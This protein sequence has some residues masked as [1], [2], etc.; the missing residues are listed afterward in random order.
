M[1]NHICSDNGCLSFIILI[2]IVG[3]LTGLIL[4]TILLAALIKR[5]N[6]KELDPIFEVQEQNLWTPY[7]ISSV[8]NY[9]ALESY[10]KTDST[11]QV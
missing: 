7:T 2:I 4:L 10:L 5:Q 1:M 11:E 3:C 6:N 8:V 9:P